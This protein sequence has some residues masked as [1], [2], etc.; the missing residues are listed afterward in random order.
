MG[1]G[2]G[3]TNHIG[4]DAW[5]GWGCSQRGVCGEPHIRAGGVG[6]HLD[7]LP[8]REG[9]NIL[10]GRHQ[11]C[12]V[13]DV[14]TRRGVGEDHS[15]ANVDFNVRVCAATGLLVALNRV[16]ELVCPGGVDLDCAGGQQDDVGC[17]DECAVVRRQC[18]YASRE[19]LNVR[20]VEGRIRRGEADRAGGACWSSAASCSCSAARWTDRTLRT[21]RTRWQDSRGRQPDRR[22]RVRKDL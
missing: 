17:A 5:R 6:C 11:F 7:C 21:R 9:Q 10:A 1:V 19:R 18:L 4:N 12:R 20:R 14:G 16:E 8:C 15:I 3:Y 22:C 2:L 13:R